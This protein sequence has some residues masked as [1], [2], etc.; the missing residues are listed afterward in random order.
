MPIRTDLRTER[1]AR[2]AGTV[3]LRDFLAALDRERDREE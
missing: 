3:A 2:D 1:A